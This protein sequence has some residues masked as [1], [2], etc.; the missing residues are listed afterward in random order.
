MP[1]DANNARFVVVVFLCPILVC[2]L[3]H[4]GCAVR[5]FA[6]GQTYLHFVVRPFYAVL[7][8]RNRMLLQSGSG[9]T[10]SQH[11][12]GWH[13]QWRRRLFELH[14]EYSRPSSIG[15]LIVSV[16]ESSKKNPIELSSFFYF[17]SHI[18]FVGH[19][20]RISRP[21][22]IATNAFR[23]IIGRTVYCRACVRRVYRVNAMQRARW[24]C[25]RQL[26][27]RARVKRASWDRSVIS[28]RTDT[29]EPIARSVHVMCAAQCQAASVSRIV[30]AR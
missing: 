2:C 20:F 7:W 9:S 8:S 12:H 26:A 13:L 28:V 18:F 23:T 29:V 25:A 10:W 30:N 15:T 21:V 27:V 14:G 22:S 19:A 11:Q 24:V 5:T 17:V 4:L 6:S 1:I 3:L 16:R